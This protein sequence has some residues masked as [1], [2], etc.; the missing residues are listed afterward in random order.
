MG[1]KLNV[2]GKCKICGEDSYIF[3]DSCARYVCEDHRTNVAIGDTVTTRVM[4]KACRE[5]NRK[6][7]IQSDTV[8]TQHGLNN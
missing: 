1:Y 3:C 6:Q 5:K 7:K 2:D 4:C 8:N